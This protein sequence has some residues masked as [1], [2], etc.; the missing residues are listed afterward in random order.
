MGEMRLRKIYIGILE[1]ERP[2]EDIGV[3]EKIILEYNFGK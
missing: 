1:G 3:N 2:I